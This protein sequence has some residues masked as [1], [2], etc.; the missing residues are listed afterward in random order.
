MLSWMLKAF[1]A[2]ANIENMVRGHN[3]ERSTLKREALN[4][5]GEKE[6]QR[7]RERDNAKV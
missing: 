3:T 2:W 4:K 5:D 1:A 6:G 7:D